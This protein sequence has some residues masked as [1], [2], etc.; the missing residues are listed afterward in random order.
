MVSQMLRA[1]RRAVGRECGDVVVE[2]V[3]E[4]LLCR[5]EAGFTACVAEVGRYLTS[6]DVVPQLTAAVLPR[7]VDHLAACLR[8]LRHPP[9]TSHVDQASVARDYD[10]RQL[11]QLQSRDDHDRSCL[12]ASNIS[13]RGVPRGY[14]RIYT[15]KGQDNKGKLAPSVQ[16]RNV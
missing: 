13:A 5:Y 11:Q 1:E 10:Y 12:E 3:D 2:D 16:R 14:E 6:V 4:S 15:S 7:L 8:R 9:T